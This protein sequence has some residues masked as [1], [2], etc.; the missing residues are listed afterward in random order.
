MP[1]AAETVVPDT[2]L[3]ELVLL[4]LELVP[5]LLVLVRPPAGLLLEALA[6][7]ELVAPD[8][9]V[10]AAAFAWAPVVWP[11]V[12]WLAVVWSSALCAAEFPGAKPSPLLP[13]APD[14]AVAV[15]P[16]VVRFVRG[17]DFVPPVPVTA[18]CSDVPAATLLAAEVEL[19]GA[20]SAAQIGSSSPPSLARMALASSRSAAGIPE[21]T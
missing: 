9:P 19:V 5:D 7:A 15:E 13:L 4:L 1:G 16:A 21:R 14:S 18:L 10:P 20:D 6:S 2:L 3:V 8:S 11:V 17:L 12:V